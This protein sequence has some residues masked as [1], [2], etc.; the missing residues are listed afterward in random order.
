MAIPHM[1][2]VFVPRSLMILIYPFSPQLGPQLFCKS[3]KFTFCTS[4]NPDPTNSRE[5]SS[6]AGHPS[7][8]T[9]SN[10]LKS[11]SKPQFYLFYKI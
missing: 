4:S 1:P 5:C 11:Q 9:P 10:T 8:T 3:Q 7:V 6:A 2:G